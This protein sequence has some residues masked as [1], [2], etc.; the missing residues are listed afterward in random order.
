MQA[1]M[2]LSPWNV[3]QHSLTKAQL[4]APGVPVYPRPTHTHSF[5]PCLLCT[6]QELRSGET[7][8]L[9]CR[10]QPGRSWFI[11]TSPRD[12]CLSSILMTNTEVGIAAVQVC[13]EHPQPPPT[14]PQCPRSENSIQQWLGGL[15]LWKHP[16]FMAPFLHLSPVQ[17][18]RWWNA[19][20]PLPATA[21]SPSSGGR[22]TQSRRH[23]AHPG[24]QGHLRPPHEL[25]RAQR[26]QLSCEVSSKTAP[27]LPE[28]STFKGD[29]A[30]LQWFWNAGTFTALHTPGTSGAQLDTEL[31]LLP[32]YTTYQHNHPMP[33][34]NLQLIVPVTHQ[35]PYTNKVQDQKQER[36]TSIWD[37]YA[38]DCISYLCKLELLLKIRKESI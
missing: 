9:P 37:K 18:V 14:S 23:C 11:A 31:R 17:A 4:P 30:R 12:S 13:P 33:K 19:K 24:A 5:C 21:V 6:Y 3:E 26:Q 1:W 20:Q 10:T 2:K 28:S 38:R 34:P 7:S 29:W 22:M 25:S 36:K 16:Y 35:S 27:A 32:G 15:S 8:F